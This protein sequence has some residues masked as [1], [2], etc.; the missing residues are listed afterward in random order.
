MSERGRQSAGHK[1]SETEEYEAKFSAVN[2]HTHGCVSECNGLKALCDKSLNDVIFP[3]SYE[4]HANLITKVLPTAQQNSL[5]AQLEGGIRAFSVSVWPCKSN[6]TKACA[7][8]Q[9]HLA[10]QLCVY[11]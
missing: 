4:A 5:S 3:M 2:S 8:L 10:S 9:V 1:Q 11:K 6:S 7:C